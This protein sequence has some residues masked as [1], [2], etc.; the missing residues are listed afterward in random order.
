MTGLRNAVTGIDVH[1]VAVHLARAA[2]TLAARPAISAAHEAGFDASLSIPVYLGDALQ[3]RFRTG[4]MFAENEI[5]IEVRDEA[6]TEL[7]FPVSLVERAENF[8][9]LMGDVSA[10][11]ETGEDALLALDDNHINDPAERR[12]IGETIKTMQRLHDEGRDHIW[13]YYTRNMVRP[14]ALSRAKVD[15][16]IGNPPW[17]QL[18]PDGGHPAGRV[19]EPEPE[20]LRHLGRRALRHPPGRG[21]PVLRPQRG[22]VSQGRAASS[23]SCCPT[24]RCRRASTPSG[25]AASGGP[26]GGGRP[27]TWTSPT[28]RRGTWSGWNPTPSSRC[29]PRWCSPASVAADA[30]GKPLAGAVEQWA[31]PGGGRR[32]GAGVIG[33]YGHRRCGRFSIR[34]CGPAMAQPYFPRVLFFVNETEN[35]AIVQAARTI[36]VNPATR[37]PGQ[38]AVEGPGPDRD[39]GPDGRTPAPVR[40]T[41]GRDR[42]PLRDPGT[43]ESAAAVEAGRCHAITR[44]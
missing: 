5:A 14:V 44:R 22:P 37:Q 17:N 4:D 13:A 36:T 10:Y 23:G 7:F 33:D 1:P 30:V 39:H 2:W 24:A 29:R 11:I 38:S 43:T 18:Q 19:A 31:G 20:P 32:R 25:G 26:A 42:R 40:R 16:V 41:P 12:M 9:A 27:S 21:G 8:D 34:P 28:S 15:V 35:T 6:N 3:L